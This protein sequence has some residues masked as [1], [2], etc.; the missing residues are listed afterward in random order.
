MTP[1]ITRLLEISPDAS[2]KEIKKAYKKR[3]KEI[4][5]QLT[6]ELERLDAAYQEVL[7]QSGSRKKSPDRQETASPPI[8][9]GS[10]IT[11]IRQE[12]RFAQ[13][14]QQNLSCPQ[15]DFTSKALSESVWQS[16]RDRRNFTPKPIS[17]QKHA[18]RDFTPKF[19]ESTKTTGEYT[20]DQLWA[21]QFLGVVPGCDLS[22]AKKLARNNG[23]DE[24]EIQKAAGILEQ[25]SPPKGFL[26]ILRELVWKV[27][28]WLPFLLAFPLYEVLLKSGADFFPGHSDP[29]LAV[30]YS[31]T[32]LASTVVSILFTVAVP[33][34]FILIWRRK[35]ARRRLFRRLD[36]TPASASLRRSISADL[37]MSLFVIALLLTINGPMF[38]QNTQNY[39]LDYENMRDEVYVSSRVLDP[40]YAYSD[41]E[42]AELGTLFSIGDEQVVD[43]RYD[44]LPDHDHPGYDNGWI[45]EATFAYLPHARLASAMEIHSYVLYD[46]NV[47]SNG[48]Y[49]QNS[50]TLDRTVILSE[51]AHL[52]IYDESF[53]SE[54]EPEGSRI[55]SRY[56]N[57]LLNTEVPCLSDR[58]YIWFDD[59]Q[60]KLMMILPYTDELA[61]QN[62]TA[63]ISMDSNG[64]I[65]SSHVIENCQPESV[66]ML[67]DGDLVFLA[68]T[69]FPEED[70][71]TLGNSVKA[72]HLNGSDLSLA[73]VSE[74]S[75]RVSPYSVI[76][77]GTVSKNGIEAAFGDYEESEHD[78]HFFINIP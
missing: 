70:S 13:R 29:E 58:Q 73:A 7:R 38:Y 56:L 16:R 33:L 40:D 44:I 31:G 71:A 50:Y 78:E 68:L 17:Q 54:D 9:L 76:R 11:R 6:W 8:S 52:R 23:L 45:H 59:R 26:Y 35:G 62:N 4:D 28:A 63:M 48:V 43:V 55:F 61:G 25:M 67:P 15:R 30:W 2:L 27:L 49:M 53:Y 24:A 51:N 75:T 21:M 46:I 5:P 77:Y 42:F 65:L 32:L 3:R 14:Q 47:R 69:A 10:S 22:K 72:V 41:H 66:F 20:S 57:D 18:E 1:E 64:N 12:Q 60:E 37:D 39:L 74:N 19:A 34:L 36:I